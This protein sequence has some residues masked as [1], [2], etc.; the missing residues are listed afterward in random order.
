MRVEKLSSAWQ[1]LNRG[2]SRSPTDTRCKKLVSGLVLLLPC[3]RFLFFPGFSFPFATAGGSL[4]PHLGLTQ[5]W[6]PNLRIC[7]FILLHI[8]ILCAHCPL[9]HSR[10]LRTESGSHSKDR[11]PGEALSSP[12]CSS[13]WPLSSSEAAASPSPATVCPCPHRTTHP[14]TSPPSASFGTCW[15]LPEV[16]GTR[17]RAGKERKSKKGGKT[18]HPSANHKQDHHHEKKGKLLRNMEL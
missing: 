14:G 1:Q 10:S 13:C 15:A 6:P 11:S 9:P 7:L 17:R 4:A 3:S 8:P 18:N 16:P 12:S 5:Q 2:R